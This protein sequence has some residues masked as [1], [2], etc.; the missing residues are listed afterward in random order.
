MI[1]HEIY[2]H[3]YQAV[4]KI[5]QSAADGT[6]DWDAVNHIATGEAFGESCLEIPPALR[7][8]K[9]PLILP[10]CTTPLDR[11]VPLPPTEIQ[12]RWL[13]SI[14]LDPR[15]RLFGDGLS[16]PE[17]IQPI[18]RPEDLVVF[19]QCNDPDPFEEDAYRRH[20]RTILQ[21]MKGKRRIRV[22]YVSRKNTKVLVRCIPYRLEYSEK[23]AKFRLLTVGTRYRETIN[24]ARITAIELLEP[25][26]PDLYL[27]HGGSDSCCLTL[28]IEDTRNALERAM[29]HFSHFRREAVQ[30]DDRRYEL[31]VFYEGEDET[32]LVIR[33]LSFGP[34]ARV[35]GP[36]R[37]VHL[38]KER[39]ASQKR[40]GPWT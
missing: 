2:G 16:L 27:P 14:S 12:L 7:S 24:V 25:Y 39:L 4:A 22:E 5:L 40:C 8:G 10:D 38:M 37:F 29:I 6:L 30:L 19:D 33:V 23:D 26:S 15:I 13:K 36:E 9:W 21:A 32:E 3:Y 11:P 1:Y 31:T 20:F 28:E 34:M 17:E 18:F 35:A